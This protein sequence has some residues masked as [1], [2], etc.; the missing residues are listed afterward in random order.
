MGAGELGGCDNFHRLGD[1]LDVA[2]RLQTALDLAEGGVGS[3]IGGIEGSG[4]AITTVYSQCLMQL[5]ME[6]AMQLALRRVPYRVAT[7]AAAFK[8]GRAALDSII[9][10]ERN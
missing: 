7:A 5:L 2:N 8:A 10:G 1:L 9:A 4:P 3:R 6:R